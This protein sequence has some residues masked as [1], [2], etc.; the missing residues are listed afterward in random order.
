MATIEPEAVGALASLWSN[1][2]HLTFVT[3]EVEAD[4]QKISF[5]RMKDYVLSN[6]AG[7]EH[8][9]GGPRWEGDTGNFGEPLTPT[10]LTASLALVRWLG[11]ECGFPLVR[12]TTLFEHNELSATLCPSGRIPW[13]LYTEEDPMTEEER[14]RLANVE[15]QVF[16]T[17]RDLNEL[18][19]GQDALPP[20]KNMLR[21]LWALAGKTWPF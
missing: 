10:Q 3:R 1:R 13:Q 5:V 17:R 19:N 6:T 8:E 7:I 12:V 2:L 16:T 18:A 20:I 21:Y 4:G 9:G 15:A 14:Q 11:R